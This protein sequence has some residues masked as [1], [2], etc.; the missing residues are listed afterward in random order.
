[1]QAFFNGLNIA[2][3]LTIAMVAR[4]SMVPR[5]LTIAMVTRVSMVATFVL[6]AT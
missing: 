5:L 3:L 6:I 2:R 1:M 4:F